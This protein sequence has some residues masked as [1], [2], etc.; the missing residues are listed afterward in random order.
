MTLARLG[1]PEGVWRNDQTHAEGGTGEVSAGS[2]VAGKK[3][4]TGSAEIS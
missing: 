2:S 3:T 4:T 1:K